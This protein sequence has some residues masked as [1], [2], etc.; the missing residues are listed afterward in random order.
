MSDRLIKKYP[1]RRLYDTEQ[2]KYITLSQLR[3]LIVGGELIKVI[4]STTEEDI[5]RTILLQIILESES[6]GNPL[7]TANMLSQII[8]FYGG[9]LQGIFGNYLE[10]SLGMFTTQQEQIRKNM[11]EDPFTAMTNLAQNNMKLWTDMQKDFFSAAGFSSP[12]KEEK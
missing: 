4:D 11:G 5:T 3:Q 7:F 1:N 8:R 12:K 9:T 6:G 10:Q 2:S